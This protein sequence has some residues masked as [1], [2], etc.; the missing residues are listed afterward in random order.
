VEEVLNGGEYQPSGVCPHQCWSETMVLQPAIEGM[1]G[2]DVRAQ[3]NRVILAPHLPAD[4]DSLNVSNIK[5]GDQSF[6]FTFRRT[7]NKYTYQF[8][9][10]QIQGPNVEFLPSFP[11]GTL[12]TKVSMNGQDAKVAIFNTSQYTSLV[13]KF[14]FINPITFEIEFDKGISVLP[15]MAYPKP[16]DPASG[17]RIISSGLKGDQYV[18]DIEGKPG[19]TDSF[20]VYINNQEIEE[21]KN[22][23]ILGKKGNIVDIEVAFEAGTSLY[24]NKSVILVLK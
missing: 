15:V 21:I 9:P 5:I 24:G 20:K 17:L 3:E 11:A 19:S 18:I 14:N 4:W 6:D 12:F 23:K 10:K 8:I 7:G 16:G 22:G 1:L 13:S 2:L